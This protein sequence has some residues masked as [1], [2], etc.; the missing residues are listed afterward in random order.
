[1]ETEPETITNNPRQSVL[2][3]QDCVNDLKHDI[4]TFVIE[5]KAMFQQQATLKL[6]NH[7][8]KPS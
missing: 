4:A 5:R 1:M 2:E 8:M 6:T 3:I 7:S